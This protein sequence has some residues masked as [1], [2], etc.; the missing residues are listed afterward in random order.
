MAFPG[1]RRGSEDRD[2]CSTAVRETR[3]EVG[4]SLGAPLG[5]LDETESGR[6]LPAGP[7]FISP[8]VFE[9]TERAETATNEEVQATVWIPLAEL[10]EPGS[11]SEYNFEQPGISATFP[12]IRYGRF[13]IWGLTYRILN[14]FFAIL[15]RELPR[16]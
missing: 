4:L 13:T 1:G 12:A 2:L 15:D 6:G 16:P 14:G 5:R 11:A 10:L 3:E 7:I 9:L 8:F